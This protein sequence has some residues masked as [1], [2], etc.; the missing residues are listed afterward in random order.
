MTFEISELVARFAGVD[1]GSTTAKAVVMDEEGSIKC[2]ILPI[3]A[4]S[5]EAG[6]KALK[7]ALDDPNNNTN[8]V[9]YV[10]AT[11]YGRVLAPFANETVTE[12]TCHAL[13]A[14][15]VM[16]AT[17]TVVD[18]GGQD[19]KA[20]S[21]DQNGKVIDFV[22]NDKCAAGTGRFLEFAAKLVL[23]VPLEEMGALSLTATAPVKISS[24]C[25]VF[26]Q[27][28]IVSLLAYGAKKEDIL[29]GLHRGIAKR[30][31]ALAKHVGVKPIVLM[32]GGVS[33]NIGVRKAL[34]EEL[35][36]KVVVPES[37]DPQLI[38]ALGASLI[39]RN[40]ALRER[41]SVG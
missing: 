38:G 39:A 35:G 36:I 14:W 15:H 1:I 10:V 34:E 19:A 12:I 8:D 23:D 28:E 31:G 26:A 6:E 32:T 25:T 2:C 9:R 24:T 41:P 13:G 21:L 17:R 37:M 20:I 27:T 4:R 16:P 40:H 5:V 3:G 7:A 30:V 29:A 22:I 11:G 18:L 33:K